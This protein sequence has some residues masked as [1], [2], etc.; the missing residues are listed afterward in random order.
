MPPLLDTIRV[1]IIR[2]VKGVS[3]FHP[4][5]NHIHHVFI[6]IGLQHRSATLI[7]AAVHIAFIALAIVLSHLADAYVVPIVLM[8]SSVFS[9]FLDRLIINYTRTGHKSIL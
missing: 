9:I 6:R 7:I 4:D 5:K 8:V 3:P 1:I 2:L